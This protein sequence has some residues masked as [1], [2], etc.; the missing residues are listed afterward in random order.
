MC[1]P[2]NR[3]DTGGPRI[4]TDTRHRYAIASWC[5]RR[6]R[7]C[8]LKKSSGN[9]GGNRN[10][11]ATASF[12]GGG[13]QKKKNQL[14]SL[15]QSTNLLNSLFCGTLAFRGTALHDLCELGLAG[16]EPG[17]VKLQLGLQLHAHA[18]WERKRAARAEIWPPTNS[19]RQTG[20][21]YRGLLG[22]SADG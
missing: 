16:F 21:V 2:T 11:S 14:S 15:A 12:G 8:S 13:S 7:A 6:K 3:H 1:R 10:H 4:H 19:Q 9:G 20:A 22:S 17:L 18:G 5:S